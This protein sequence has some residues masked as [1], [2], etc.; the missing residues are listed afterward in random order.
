[1]SKGV[2]L[3]LALYFKPEA[4]ESFVRNLPGML[5][6]TANFPGFRS[7]QAYRHKSDPSQILFVE[8]W[9]SEEA[10]TKYMAWRAE[11]GDV[12]ELSAMLAQPTRADVWTTLIA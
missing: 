3:T 5:K 7:A 8:E 10:H 6:E 9:E 2:T 11:T 12:D 1:M 4:V